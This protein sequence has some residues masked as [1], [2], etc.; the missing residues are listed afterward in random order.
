MISTLI[1]DWG[2]T[3]MRDIPG[4]PGPMY[5]WE[6]VGWIPG[7]KTALESVYRNYEMA[8]ATNAGASDTEAMIKALTRVGA[9]RYF[10]SFYSSKD[11]GVRKPDPEFFRIICE[12]MN[13]RPS[14]C[15]MIGNSYDKDICGAK[16]AGLKTI[17]FNE[18]Q[19][20][21]NADKA[22]IVIGKM[23]DLLNAVKSF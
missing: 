6:A 4:K 22:D 2:D 1:F 18:N 19:T 5:T 3:L 17:F 9:D 10:Q 20:S 14:E 11:L 23:E 12:R 8:V 15:V 16:D 7:A 21:V 13:R